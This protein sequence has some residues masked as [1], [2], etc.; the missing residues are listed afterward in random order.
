M[1][2][3]TAPLRPGN[4]LLWQDSA[5]RQRWFRRF[6]VA[7]IVMMVLHLGH[8][9]GL[10]NI[11]PLERSL[12]LLAMILYVWGRPLVPTSVAALLLMGS[13]VFVS[14]AFTHFDLFE[15]RRTLMALV[16]L[17]TML[18]FLLVRTNE[19]DA[20]FLLR[21]ISV[22]PLFN[23]ALGVLIALA[24]GG[25][26][27]NPDHTGA[28]R[29]GGST[30][31]SFLAASCYAATLASGFLFCRKPSWT[32]AGLIVAALGIAALSG[33]RMATACAA[34][35]ALLF[36]LL[37]RKSG[38]FKGLVIL[39]GAALA[40]LFLLTIGDQLV[41]RFL[42]GST[43]GR[44]VISGHLLASTL[45]HPWWGVGFGHHGLLIPELVQ[46]YTGTEAAH[47]ELLRLRLELGWVGVGLF[48]LG[49]GVLWSGLLM[50]RLW[51]NVV[52]LGLLGL[53][54]LYSS[55]DNTLFFVACLLAL[56]A[57]GVGSQLLQI[58]P[59]MAP[60]GGT[61]HERTVAKSASRRPPWA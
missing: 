5:W 20:R 52:M 28:L 8:N 26:L 17:F 42:S 37:S 12:F 61:A 1:N 25:H 48:A 21:S 6:W 44:D 39:Y 56:I 38:V 9:L 19:V 43:S 33:T 45:T 27:L 7:G 22:I 49:W 15:W 30:G 55:T 46:R 32:D 18:G 58:R 40:A 34:G 16:A 3:L 50:R 53:F 23:V 47:N 59:T 24:F 4:L 41:L 2:G 36:L 57:L 60:S 11:N 29:L 54:T 35:S 51:S 14:A 10:G 31:P 13:A